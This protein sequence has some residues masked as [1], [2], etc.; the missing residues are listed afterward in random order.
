MLVAQQDIRI[1]LQNE[2]LLLIKLHTKS[3]FYP[4]SN[5]N[6]KLILVPGD[7][8]K[9]KTLDG[10]VIPLTIKDGLT[11]HDVCPCTDQEYDALP[12]VFFTSELALNPTVFDHAFDNESE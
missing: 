11:C 4:F 10:F 9:I 12:H 1:L 8:Q 2:V 3:C 6:D 5:A 7:K